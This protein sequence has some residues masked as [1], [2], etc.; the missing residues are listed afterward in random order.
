MSHEH[1]STVSVVVQ[2]GSGVIERDEEDGLLH[3]PGCSYAAVSSSNITRHCHSHPSHLSSSEYNVKD[4]DLTLWKC[5]LNIEHQLLICQACNVAHALE[6]TE[7]S[8]H[9]EGHGL[10]VPSALVK[11]FVE[12][13]G[14]RGFKELEAAEGPDMPFIAEVPS[15]LGIR[16]SD[17][18]CFTKMRC[19]L[20]TEAMGRHCK[21]QHGG[22]SVSSLTSWSQVQSLFGHPRQIRPVHIPSVPHGSEDLFSLVEKTQPTFAEDILPG[23]ENPQIGTFLSKVQWHQF[24]NTVQTKVRLFDFYTQCHSRQNELDKLWQAVKAYTDHVTNAITFATTLNL[25]YVNSKEAGVNR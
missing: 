4:V 9:L 21:R 10:Q 13:H 8:A 25:R 1:C 23:L 18:V 16:C 22:Q 24:L 6:P 2:G 3:C 12:H 14:I 20:S 7:I 15:F 11:A 17:S 5:T 19:Y